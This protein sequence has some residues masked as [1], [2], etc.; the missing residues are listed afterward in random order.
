MR[1]LLPLL[2]DLSEAQY[3]LFMLTQ[4]LV[5]QHARGA[6]PSL[7]DADVAEA[8]GTVASTL[9]TAGKGI[10]YE[11]RAA[12]I[13]AQRLATE[14]ARAVAEISQRAG[15]DATRAERDAAVALRRLERTAREAQSAIPDA[16]DAR[17]SWMALAARVMGGA[18]TAAVEPSGE[19]P[20]RI[21]I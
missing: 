3:R 5:L 9:E 2:G 16:G 12:S 6:T 11:H 7:L 13:P 1:F 20:P 17:T 18:R 19:D 14:I 21:I 4:A 8:V 10:I 15:A